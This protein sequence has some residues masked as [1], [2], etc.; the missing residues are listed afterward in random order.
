MGLVFLFNILKDHSKKDRLPFFSFF[1]SDLSLKILQKYSLSLSL[2]NN[3]LQLRT[4]LEGFVR[5]AGSLPAARSSAEP[6][7]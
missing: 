7:F 4:D 1:S 5:A 2:L 6:S 3:C